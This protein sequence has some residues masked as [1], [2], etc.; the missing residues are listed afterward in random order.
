MV[1]YLTRR[2]YYKLDMW[3]VNVDILPQMSG[4]LLLDTHATFYDFL[5]EGDIKNERPVPP[6]QRRRRVLCVTV[7]CMC[8]VAGL[9][10]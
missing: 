6:S 8:V 3:G 1:D 5:H 2:V 9:V 4:L 7:E 10:E